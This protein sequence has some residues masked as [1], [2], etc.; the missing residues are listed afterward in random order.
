MST[1]DNRRHE[2]V[3]NRILAQHARWAELNAN[4]LNQEM[5]TRCNEGPHLVQHASHY[6]QQS[7]A[8]GQPSQQPH[9]PRPQPLPRPDS[10]AVRNTVA[11]DEAPS[12][13]TTSVQPVH[14]T[15][16]HLDE[17]EGLDYEEFEDQA[18][19]Q[20]AQEL[21]QQ[22]EIEKEACTLPL[23]CPSLTFMTNLP[24]SGSSKRQVS[25]LFS[26]CDWIV[27]HL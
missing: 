9:G 4:I 20:E 26:F 16:Q 10:D 23:H 13:A 25:K 2:N 11:T 1:L 21:E 7:Q 19:R 12:A 6:Q 14:I 8:G 15:N 27:M 18:R 24:A 5:E 17:D 3:A 22:R